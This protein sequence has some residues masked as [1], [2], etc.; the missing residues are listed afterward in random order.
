MTLDRYIYRPLRPLFRAIA[1][2]LLNL[3]RITDRHESAVARLTRCDLCGC[4][5]DVT[6]PSVAVCRR[7]GTQIGTAICRWDYADAVRRGYAP[8]KRESA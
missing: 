7:P 8:I 3:D 4:V 2:R 6:H 5:V 1:H